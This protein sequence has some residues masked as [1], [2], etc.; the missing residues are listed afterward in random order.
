MYPLF[1]DPVLGCRRRHVGAQ[2]ID[3]YL[4]GLL[5]WEGF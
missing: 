4:L 2:G 3:Y 5:G 1:A